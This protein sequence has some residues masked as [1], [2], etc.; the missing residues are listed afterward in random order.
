MHRFTDIYY[1]MIIIC[2]ITMSEPLLN[3]QDMISPIWLIISSVIMFGVIIPAKWPAE[4]EF[5][6]HKSLII[7]FSG[8][9]LTPQSTGSCMDHVMMCT[10]NWHSL[11]L[12]TKKKK[13]K[14]IEKILSPDMENWRMHASLVRLSCRRVRIAWKGNAIMEIKF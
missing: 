3:F 5:I 12:P 1:I 2:L 9:Y 10:R 6:N 4:S 13:E 7:L 11:D 8:L 14:N